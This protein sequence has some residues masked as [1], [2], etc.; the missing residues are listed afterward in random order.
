MNT[1][2]NNDLIAT[3]LE[4]YKKVQDPSW[5]NHQIGSDL[6]LTIS[7]PVDNGAITGGDHDVKTSNE[8]NVISV[9]RRKDLAT[10]GFTLVDQVQEEE[11][12]LIAKLRNGIIRLEEQ[13]LPATFIFLFDEAWE[14]ATHSRNTLQQ[15][16]HPKNQFNFDVLAWYIP[17]GQAGF[18][19]HRDRQPEDAMSSFHTNDSDI[20]NEPKFVTQW[21][22]LS[23]ATPSNSCLY[24]IPKGCDPGYLTGDNDEDKDPLQT[25]LPDKTAYQMIRAIPRQSGQ[26][27]LFTHRIIHWGSKSDPD[28]DNPRIAISFVCSDPDYEA[29]FV[30]FEFSSHK[31]HLLPF[32]L[33]LLVVCAQL[34][35]YHQRFEPSRATIKACYDYC[36]ENEKYLGEAFRQKVFLEFVKAMEE[37]KRSILHDT[38]Q[39]GASK[40]A[41]RNDQNDDDDDD[42]DDEDDAMMEEMLNAEKEGYGEFEDDFDALDGS[43]KRG[44]D[45][46]DED[47]KSSNDDDD[48]DDVDIFGKRDLEIE[49]SKISKKVKRALKE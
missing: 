45:S 7:E 10:N 46:Y 48:N 36:K 23:D 38:E 44:A 25:A 21:I 9:R 37:K 33:R 2:C 15:A 35:C 18:S 12:K 8:T 32:H 5:W 26:S 3:L 1:G 22:A 20:E 6:G 47:D 11:T 49:D 4:R 42:E 16:C 31:S 30:N 14:L 24:V 28:H 40:L 13:T 29:P 34:I 41:S 19:P 39:Q 43:E 17:P 27:L